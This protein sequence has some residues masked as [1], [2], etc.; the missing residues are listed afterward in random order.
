MASRKKNKPSPAGQNATNRFTGINASHLTIALAMLLIVLAAI[1]AYSPALNGK[2]IWD[3]NGHVTK[4]ELRSFTGL[5]RNWFEVGATQQ[6]YPL[7]HTV[8]WLEYKFFGEHPL[9]YHLINLAEHLAAAWLVFLIL[10]KLRIPG[11]L[12]AAAIFALHPVMV[13][14][15]AWITE[16]K[17]TL[18]TVFYLS[19]MLSY[20]QF[21]ESRRRSAYGFATFL[22]VLGLLTKT[23]TATLPAALLVIFWWQRGKLSWRRDVVPLIPWFALGL[24]A[25]LLTAWVERKLIGA[26]G[27][28]F[29]LTLAQRFLLAGRVPWFYLAKLIWPSHLIFIYPRWDVDPSVWWQWLFPM[30]TLIVS[31]GLWL[32]R[33]KS[34]APL[35]GWLFFVGTLFPVLG[36]LNVYPFIFSFVA[37]HFQYLASLGLIVPLVAGLTLSIERLPQTTRKLGYVSCCAMLVALA[38]LTSQQS[39]MYSDLLVLYQI[40][41]QRNPVCWMAYNNLGH[42]LDR[43]GHRQQAIQQYQQ[44]LQIKPDYAEAHN[45]LGVVLQGEGRLQEAA[46]NFQHAIRIKPNYSEAFNN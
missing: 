1:V 34:R 2:F 13:E 23:V 18:S 21:D 16:Q 37:D 3:D 27:A 17:N 35:A 19:A 15:V 36:F 8:F 30:A 4:P 46:D 29:E 42:E 39:R 7:L 12:L 31:V 14:S 22:F 26:E 20:L 24:A 11:A 44:A 43:Q 33:K 10:R 38:V 45:N 32:A 5:Y 25:G 9:G 40:T 6:Y 41:L 28:A